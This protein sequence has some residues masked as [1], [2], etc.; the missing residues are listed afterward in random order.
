MKLRSPYNKLEKKKIDFHFNQLLLLI[1]LC[2]I[3]FGILFSTLIF[4]IPK[5]QFFEGY[6]EEWL[7]YSKIT[8]P[9]LFLLFIVIQL[10]QTV[11]DKRAKEKV[12]FLG[13]VEKLEI[14]KRWAYRSMLF[15]DKSTPS[16][17]EYFV[18]INNEKYFLPKEDYKLLEVGDNIE[19]NYSK[20]GGL[21][22]SVVKLKS[23]QSNP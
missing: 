18:T 10:F 23:I 12:T 14:K 22:L 5:H 4:P 3:V 1:F 17:K 16:L 7:L 2:F 8:G 6:R 11:R 15:W 9:I 13:E 19:I 21:F 20:Y